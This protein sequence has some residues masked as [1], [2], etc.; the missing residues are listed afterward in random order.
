M[1]DGEHME[2][3]CVRPLIS[4]SEIRTQGPGW[5]RA[6]IWLVGLIADVSIAWS[7]SRVSTTLKLLRALPSL[8]ASST[9]L[10]DHECLYS[11]YLGKKVA[12]VYRAHRE[13]RGTKI[14]VIWGKVTRPHGVHNQWVSYDIRFLNKVAMLL[15]CRESTIPTQPSP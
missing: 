14:R 1:S 2:I 3:L 15:W 6:R 8:P 10:A 11:F 5:T 13:I 12:F 7:R 4:C 9:C